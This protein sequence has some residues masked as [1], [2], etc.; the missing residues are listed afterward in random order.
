MDPRYQPNRVNPEAPPHFWREEG[1]LSTAAQRSMRIAGLA[2]L[3]LLGW[4]AVTRD[5]HPAS[6]AGAAV[7]AAL[8]AWFAAP[9]FFE[10]NPLEQIRPLY[11]LDL[12]ALFFVTWLA[13]G[14]LASAE[15]IWR[16]LTRRYHPGFVRIRT[17][18]RSRLGRVLLANAITL[19]PGT[20]SL[21]LHDRHIFLHWFDLK[22]DHTVRAG[23][24]IKRRLEDY[25]K[26]ILE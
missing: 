18:L 22:S 6:L 25:L 3:C 17:R 16:M 15:L 19:V 2:G 4:I 10:Q 14:Y 23:D 8:S 5:V 20:L 1:R 12:L 13:E 24:L 9:F 11:R 26:R 21:W 7:M